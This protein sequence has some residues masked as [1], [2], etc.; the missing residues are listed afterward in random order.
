MPDWYKYALSQLSKPGVS[1]V[2]AVGSPRDT[3]ES[4]P[5]LGEDSADHFSQG[6]QGGDSEKQK[7]ENNICLR[8]ATAKTDENAES[9]SFVEGH[10]DYNSGFD[11][12]TVGYS[13]FAPESDFCVVPSLSLPEEKLPK[14]AEI[15]EA[16]QGET[17]ELPKL[18]EFSDVQRG[19]INRW[20]ASNIIAWERSCLG[21][22]KSIVVGQAWTVLSNGESTARFHA[23]CK[24]KWLAEMEERALKALGFA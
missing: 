6:A 20:I 11:N 5:T 14:A 13:E 8:K 3:Q 2:L 17:E 24:E 7:A 15:R 10:P 18:P 16:S 12:L 19:Q 4:I 21:C 1:S 22:R 9:S 23:P